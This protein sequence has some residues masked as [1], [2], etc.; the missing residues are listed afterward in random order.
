MKRKKEYK[1]VVHCP[2]YVNPKLL[3]ESL[4]YF[5]EKGHPSYQEIP[6]LSSFEPVVEFDPEPEGEKQDESIKENEQSQIDPQSKVGLYSQNFLT[7]IQ[8]KK[9]FETIL[10]F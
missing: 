5:K 8:S 9:I 6:I 7:V 4:N 3:L 1:N 10:M 2:S